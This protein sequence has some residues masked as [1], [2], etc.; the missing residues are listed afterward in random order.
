[1]F[2]QKSDTRNDLLRHLLLPFQD[3]RLRLLHYCHIR[4]SSDFRTL[5]CTAD[6]YTSKVSV[7]LLNPSLSQ[8]S[9]NK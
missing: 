2:L 3:L 5:G 6:C 8:R 4:P 1:M 9:Q 7:K